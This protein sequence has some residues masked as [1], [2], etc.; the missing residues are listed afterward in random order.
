MGGRGQRLSAEAIPAS[1][2]KSKAR[3]AFEQLGF[4][5]KDQGASLTLEGERE[6]FERALGVGLDVNPEVAPGQAIA[7]PRGEPQLP[8]GVRELVEAVAFPKRA[9]MFGPPTG[10]RRKS[11]A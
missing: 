5:V 10:E 3:K 9:H 4:T 6:T 1:G 11:N 2:S 7:T 8:D